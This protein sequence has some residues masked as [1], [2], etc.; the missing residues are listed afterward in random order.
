MK[1]IKHFP[2]DRAVALTSLIEYEKNQ[3]VSMALSHSEHAQLSLFTFANGEMVSEESYQGDTI[4][5][6]L[7]GETNIT[8]GR[9]IIALKAGESLAVPAQT[10][11]AIGGGEAFKML[12]ITINASSS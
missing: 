10:Y 8:T 9:N 4:Y 2:I 12:Q 5:L 3:V 1:M 7:D 11:H 6:L